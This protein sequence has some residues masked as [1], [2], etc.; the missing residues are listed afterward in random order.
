VPTDEAGPLPN[1]LIIGA[2]KAGTTSLAAWLS[3]HPDVF[4]APEKETRFF[5][6]PSRYA[7]GE[8]WYRRQFAGRRDEHAVGDATPMMS[9]SIAVGRMAKH[10]PSAKLIAL[11]RHPVD[12]AYSH[13]Q[14]VRA[15]GLEPRDFATAIAAERTNPGSAM[16]K[17]P[18][19]YLN[20]GHYLRQ[21]EDVSAHFPRERLHV[22]LFDDLKSHPQGTFAGVLRFL[23]VDPTAEIAGIGETHDPRPRYRLPWLETALRHWGGR[24]PRRLL[25]R[26]KQAN[27]APAPPYEPLDPTLRADIA[28][29]YA[30]E[31]PLLGRWLGR[32]LSGWLH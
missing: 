13:Y 26:V 14:H 19:D 24:P 27:V 5:N 32:D 22:V 15:M 8:Q 21:L 31:I 20:K 12:R 6:Q 2:M 3:A 28:R 1:F 4:I 23:G 11:L 16:G 25:E 29:D 17:V 7:A 18:K 9:N 10:V 30:E